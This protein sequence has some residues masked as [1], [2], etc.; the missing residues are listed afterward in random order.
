MY[1]SLIKKGLL[2][3]LLTSLA[4]STIAAKPPR[5]RS[6]W[7]FRC[8]LDTK[9]RVLVLALA[10]NVW[11]AYDTPN[12]HLWKV[13]SGGVRF[14]GTIYTTKHGPQ[15]TTRGDMLQDDD[16]KDAQPWVILKGGQPVPFTV[17]YRGHRFEGPDLQT[18]VLTTELKIKEGPVITVEERPD[19]QVTTTSVST[20]KS[21]KEA[22]TTPSGTSCLSLTR[23]ITVRSAAPLADYEIKQYLSSG[24]QR[25][26]DDLQVTGGTFVKAARKETYGAAT[27]TTTGTT[28]FGYQGWLSLSAT[29]PTVIT[30]RYP[31][32]QP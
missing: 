20:V 1:Q 25:Q 13:W 24:S 32:L 18:I 27:G 10:P 17:Q 3:L 16:N 19:V 14:E 30:H 26:E 29:V 2:A 8:V 21:K 11:A 9:P 4:V 22:T 7:A 28:H 31:D 12:G 23:Q 5:G 6:C 15:P